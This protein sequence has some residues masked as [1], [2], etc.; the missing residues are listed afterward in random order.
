MVVLDRSEFMADPLPQGGFVWCIL[1][2]TLAEIELN[3]GERGSQ[4]L[5]AQILDRIGHVLLGYSYVWDSNKLLIRP[6]RSLIGVTPSDD[7]NDIWALAHEVT[8]RLLEKF[9]FRLDAVSSQQNEIIIEQDIFLTPIIGLAEHNQHST[10]ETA[11]RAAAAAFAISGDNGQLV[12]V[13]DH[14]ADEQA[15][16]T[17]N[18]Q[19]QQTFLQALREQRL[20]VVFQPQVELET[21]LLYGFEALLRSPA[22]PKNTL[23]EL[24]PPELV[25]L[26]AEANLLTDLTIFVIRKSLSEAA[27]WRKMSPHIPFSISVNILP[28]TLIE[29]W[30]AIRRE[31]PGTGNHGLV[32]ELTETVDGFNG[33]TQLLIERLSELQLLGVEIAI[34]DFGIGL[35]NIDRIS[36]MPCNEIKLDRS[37]IESIQQGEAHANLVHSMIQLAKARGLRVVAEGIEDLAQWEFLAESNCQVGQGYYISRPLPASG[38]TTLF[39][40]LGKESLLSSLG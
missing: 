25:D 21:G 28:R 29:G 27:F 9:S 13:F 5:K 18:F 17:S 33:S 39:Q 11:R 31:I 15:V 26:A 30:R 34:D 24:S 35:S 23:F 20:Q 3:V 14:R 1:F 8:L 19:L 38:I 2:T 32:L 4:H 12:S 10:P 7:L 37:L 22:D 16:K 6:V 36:T 40:R